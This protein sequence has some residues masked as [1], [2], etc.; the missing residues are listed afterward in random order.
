MDRTLAWVIVAALALLVIW[1]LIMGP[2]FVRGRFR[3][4]KH[5]SADLEGKQE[6][7]VS[8]STAYGED[9]SVTAT[10]VGS[11]VEKTRSVGKGIRIGASTT[12]EPIEKKPG[13]SAGPKT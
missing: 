2:R 5:V 8:S 1:A 7:R 9:I 3:F 12:P 11:T 4:G 6:A 10:G 13:S